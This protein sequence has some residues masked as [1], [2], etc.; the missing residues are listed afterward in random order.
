MG[1]LKEKVIAYGLATLSLFGGVNKAQADNQVLQQS[2]EIGVR[3]G[4]HLKVYDEHSSVSFSADETNKNYSKTYKLMLYD[5]GG[6]YH[7]MSEISNVMQN[8]KNNQSI[9]QAIVSPDGRIINLDFY[10]TKDFM[11]NKYFDIKTGKEVMNDSALV[12]E[13]NDRWE[14]KQRING[15]RNIK[16]E[17][18]RNAFYRL[19]EQNR[20]ML[21]TG[22][23]PEAYLESHQTNATIKDYELSTNQKGNELRESY[24]QIKKDI[25]TSGVDRNELLRNMLGQ[26]NSGR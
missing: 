10:D 24:N 15:V 18:D 2:K 26:G 22:T 19:L 5:I 8:N 11:H 16:N 25:K 20:K 6:G 23:F 14:R 17:E 3:N 21:E 7:V 4:E 13:N 9:T 1:K 12:K